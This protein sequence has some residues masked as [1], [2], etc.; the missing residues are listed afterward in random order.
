[1]RAGIADA[2]IAVILALILTMMSF[3]FGMLYSIKGKIL[4]EYQ[5][6][7]IEDFPKG[8]CCYPIYYFENGNVLKKYVCQEQSE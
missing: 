8:P 1:M 3:T 4:C 2:T 6:T 5:N 7:K